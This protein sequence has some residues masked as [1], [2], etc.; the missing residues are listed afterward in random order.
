MKH[1]VLYSRNIY[2]SSR[3]LVELIRFFSK[4][5]LDHYITQLD[6]YLDKHPNKYKSHY[7]TMLNWAR[8][9]KIQ[10]RYQKEFETP[11]EVY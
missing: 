8:R 4:E 11:K 1:K 9:D 5:E 10:P 7:R 2:L 3:E 6:S